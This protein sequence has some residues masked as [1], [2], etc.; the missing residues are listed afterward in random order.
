MPPLP[1]WKLDELAM[2]A[3]ELAARGRTAP[4]PM[5]GAIVVS[6]AGEILGRGWHRATGQPHAEIEALQDARAAGRDVTGWS[7]SSG[8]AFRSRRP[9]P[10]C[11]KQRPVKTRISCGGS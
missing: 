1:L 3:I 5:V 7:G 2:E 6:L 8:R 4:N 9:A 10:L 11:G